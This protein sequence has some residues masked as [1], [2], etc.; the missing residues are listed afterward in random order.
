MFWKE[1]GFYLEISSLYFT[2]TPIIFNILV[3]NLY[4]YFLQLMLD[5]TI[6]K[7]IHEW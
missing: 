3:D 7:I 2:F 4:G 1:C 6:Q 5:P